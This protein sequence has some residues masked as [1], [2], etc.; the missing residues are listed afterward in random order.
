MII[1]KASHED[2]EHIAQLYSVIHDAE[3][4]G[5]ITIGWKRNV[6][7]TKQTAIDAIGKENMFLSKDNDEISFSHYQSSS[8]TLLR[9][10]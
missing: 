10:C 4:N 3:E 2:A 5:Q 9:L 1:Y 8:V 6:Y 7:P